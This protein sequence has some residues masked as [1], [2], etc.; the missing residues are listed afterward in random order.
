MS[1]YKVKRTRN[2]FIDC[3]SRATSALI[4]QTL[5][6]VT[7]YASL[8]VRQGYMTS[9]RVYTIYIYIYKQ[10]K[11]ILYSILCLLLSFYTN[12]VQHKVNRE[13]KR[14]NL[15]GEKCRGRNSDTTRTN[16]ER[17]HT[18]ESTRTMDFEWLVQLE[19]SLEKSF[20]NISQLSLDEVPIYGISDHFEILPVRKIRSCILEFPLCEIFYTRSI[21]IVR[22]IL[23]VKN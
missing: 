9:S 12:C 8:S 17:E 20:L 1:N 14:E 13:R 15:I 16:D 3:L 2:I 6:S 11:Y 22:K 19:V 21:S 4:L 18:N 7:L 10:R 23:F 5:A